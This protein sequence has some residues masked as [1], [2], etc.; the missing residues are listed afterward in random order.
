MSALLVA[1]AS[2]SVVLRSKGRDG[3][4]PALGCA[5]PL[6]CWIIGNG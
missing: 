3:V 6:L 4:G 2:T 1:A 5:G